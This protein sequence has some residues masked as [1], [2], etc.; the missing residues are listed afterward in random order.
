MPDVLIV[1]ESTRSEAAT[2]LVSALKHALLNQ[3]EPDSHTTVDVVSS[4]DL[5]AN[6]STLDDRL[7]CPL[8]LHLPPILSLQANALYSACRDIDGLRQQLTSWQ[9]ATGEGNLWLPI[10]LTA[11]G[12]LYAEVIGFESGAFHSSE[13]RYKQPIHLSDVQRQPLYA[14]SQ[15]LLRSLN[16]LPAVYLMQFGWQNETLCFDR[17]L[18]FPAA[19][20]LA[21][22]NVQRPDLFACHWHCLLG[23]PIVDLAIV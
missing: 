12:P 9:Y 5:S 3:C 10:V 21:S 8:T 13:Q 15:R 4:S 7:L 18:P 22:L 20:A 17:L 2:Q 14:L 19:P 23:K 6:T 11:K 1:V 16:A